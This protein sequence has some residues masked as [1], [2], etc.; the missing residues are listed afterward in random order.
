MSPS[1]NDNDGN[2]HARSDT[3]R[4]HDDSDLIDRIAS[5]PT[6]QG[7]SGGN[8]ARDVATQAEEERVADPEAREGVSKADEVAHGTRVPANKPRGPDA[9]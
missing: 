5:A 9:G 1:R 7:R 3:A 4:A 2:G 6:E 8:L